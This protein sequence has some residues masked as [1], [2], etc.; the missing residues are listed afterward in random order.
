MADE[1]NPVMELGPQMN[2]SVNGHCQILDGG[3]PKNR[4]ENSSIADSPD[5]DDDGQPSRQGTVWTATSHIVT[6]ILGSGVLALAWSLAQLGWIAGVLTLVG[7]A[8]VTY[9]T[10]V[11][12]EDTHRYT[13]PITGRSRRNYN[14]MQAVRTNL[15]SKHVFMCG[16]VQYSNLVGTAIGYTV[17]SALSM[18]AVQRSICFHNRGHRHRC[19]VSNNPYMAGFGVCQLIFSQIPNFQNLW[20]LSILAAAM[21]F[22]YSS[23]TFGLGLSKI[24][25]GGHSKGTLAGVLIGTGKGRVSSAMKTWRVLQAF[26]TISFAYSFSTILI[27]IQDTLR[28]PP[29][30]QAESKTMK[31]ATL[32]GMMV[33]TLCYV[34]VASTGYLAF[35]NDVPA[36][37]L[38]GFGFYNPFWLVDLANIAVVIH[39]V[40]AYQVFAQP[41]F[42]LIENEVGAK[43]PESKFIHRD[44]NWKVPCV[45][46]LHI[47]WFRILWRSIFVGFT[48]F[49]AMLLP[50]FTDITGLLGALSFW[51]LTVYF[52]IEMYI[53]A[54]EIQ[55]WSKQW[56][57]LQMLSVSCLIISIGSGIGSFEGIVDD[58]KHYTP[59][60]TQL[61]K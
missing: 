51:P 29:K 39:L 20:W 56:I 11:L 55:A 49:I 33:T 17:T 26:G 54:R 32:L 15:G 19:Y 13:D 6:A 8:F 23:I 24:I 27:E 10:A 37:I 3:S 25:E 42:S 18:V 48:T 2:G 47:N 16:L 1:E 9:F 53:K 59:F 60:R 7:F 57:G 21:A 5:V 22:L 50:F 40:G 14:Y 30:Y 58:L 61:P 4:G 12:L 28:G 46:L 41:V 38:T 43:W 44:F 36:N 34:A 45:G 31:R 35:G 52:P